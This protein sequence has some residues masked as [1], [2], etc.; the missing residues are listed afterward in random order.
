MA[1]SSSQRIA[2]IGGGQLAQMIGAAAI[3]LGIKVRSA[4]A[5]G[6]C[7]FETCEP[8]TNDLTN[9][10]SVSQFL[11]D[12][13]VFTFESEHEGLDFVDHV[14]AHNIPIYPSADFVRIAGDRLLEKQ[15]LIVSEFRLRLL[16]KFPLRKMNELWLCG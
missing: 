12:V 4:G 13:D 15:N 6:S 3:G 16:L 14:V 11:E 1:S 7:A 10:E 5:P 8:F 2:C 9:E